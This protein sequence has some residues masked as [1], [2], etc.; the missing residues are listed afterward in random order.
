V[1]RSSTT[2]F[3]EMKMAKKRKTRRAPARRRRAV[4]TARPARRRR[5]SS[6]R[7]FLGAGS[8][9]NLNPIGPDAL[10][11]VAGAT[12][13]RFAETIL[14]GEKAPIKALQNPNTF[15]RGAVLGVAGK[16]VGNAMSGQYGRAISD[17]AEFK[18][19]DYFAASILAYMTGAGSPLM[20]ADEKTVYVDPDTGAEYLLGADG[21]PY[22]ISGPMAQVNVAG[23]SVPI[24]VA[25]YLAGMSVEPGFRMN[26]GMLDGAYKA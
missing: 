11:K 21:E 18:M 6:S 14:F 3:K 4:S 13:I 7:G 5:K 25:G 17:A 2:F 22:Q 26:Q 10:P 20:G 16:F 9:R 24:N 12:G 23:D 19:Y 1:D 15:L 8:I